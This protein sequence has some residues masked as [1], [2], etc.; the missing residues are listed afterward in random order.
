MYG[1]GLLDPL[2]KFPPAVVAAVI[3]VKMFWRWLTGGSQGGGRGIDHGC[4]SGNASSQT[5]LMA[6]LMS[7]WSTGHSSSRMPLLR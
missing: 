7:L 5:S 2:V 3:A 4:S 1:N 6:L